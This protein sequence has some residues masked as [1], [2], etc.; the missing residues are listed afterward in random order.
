MITL[1]REL[2]T[3]SNLNT[4]LLRDQISTIPVIPPF[5][6]RIQPAP[7]PVIAEPTPI[8]PNYEIGILFT[9]D[10]QDIIMANEGTAQGNNK[11][12][13]A[14]MFN[15]DFEAIEKVDIPPLDI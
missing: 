3:A 14:G 11:A 6:P 2:V 10:N 1:L 8:A 13:P 7:L 4:T 15:G 5:E 12:Q 9:A